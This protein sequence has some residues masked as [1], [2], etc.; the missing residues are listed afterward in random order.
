MKLRDTRPW[1]PLYHA[2]P[3]R[4]AGIPGLSSNKPMFYLAKDKKLLKRS[5]SSLLNEHRDI[6]NM[7][8][9]R[10]NSGVRGMP[11]CIH[12]RLK[13]LESMIEH[14]GKLLAE[15]IAEKNDEQSQ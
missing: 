5:L 10:K 14:K 2:D 12:N 7:F 13:R 8:R 3:A 11:K 6:Q 9:P 4:R 1:A 15:A